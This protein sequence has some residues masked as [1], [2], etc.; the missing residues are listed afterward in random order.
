MPTPVGHSLAGAVIYALTTRGTHLLRSWRWGVTCMVV[1]ALADIDFFPALFGNVQLAN[2]FHRHLTHT[3]LF[4]VVVWIM[5]FIVLRI[6]RK[7]RPLRA[8]VVLFACSAS[9]IFLDLLG[10]DTRPPIGVPFLW[11]FVRRSFKL[12]IELFP[13]LC[14]DTYSEIF[15][16][17]NLGV[18]A[19]EV[20]LFGGL[21][22]II[23]TLKIRFGHEERQIN[24]SEGEAGPM[25]KGS[26]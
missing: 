26:P 1:A 5:A 6:L 15:S 7:D 25:Q 18:V 8:S 16:L 21:I 4:A 24:K 19:Y 9:H 23:V 2:R 20:L 14:K 3:L 12:P 10:K 17:H 13:D 11:P 22:A